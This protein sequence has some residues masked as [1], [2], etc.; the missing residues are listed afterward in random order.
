MDSTTKAKPWRR[1]LTALVRW[2]DTSAPDAVPEAEARQIDCEPL[3]VSW[4]RI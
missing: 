2:F 3:A 4:T 1:T